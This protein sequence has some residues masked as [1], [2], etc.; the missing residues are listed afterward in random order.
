ML[1]LGWEVSKWNFTVISLNY[2]YILLVSFE[3]DRES[4]DSVNPQLYGGDVLKI[5]FVGAGK[6]GFSLGK[7]FSVNN[8]K[9]SGYYS[10]N[11]NS[12]ERAAE[13]TNSKAYDI[14]ENIVIE[15]DALFITTPDD[16]IKKIWQSIKN[17]KIKDKLI[18][19]TS[20]SLS[21]N[22]F[23]DIKS[24]GAFGYSVHPMF[25]FSDK[26]NTYKQLNSAYFSIEGEKRYLYTLKSFIEKLGNTVFII[27][28]DRKALYHLANVMV[29]NMVLSIIGIGE[30]YLC[31][32]GVDKGMAIKALYPLICANIHN[33]KDNGILNSLTGPIER[34]D[35]E[36]IKKHFE[37]MPKKHFELYKELSKELLYLAVEK[38]KEKDYEKIFNFLGGSK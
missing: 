23:S 35:L 31:E 3:W 22:I 7:Y 24:K 25:P 5:G 10:K 38:N 21:S 13:F 4:W 26:Y 15:S 27:D 16:E 11:Y 37:V 2:N 32:C 8:V 1:F 17:I 36:T 30:N 33:I 29:S 14:L 28:A 19:H 12:A 20:G 6:V 34:G 18:I 9:L